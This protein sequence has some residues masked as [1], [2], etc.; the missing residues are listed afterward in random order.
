[1]SE[2]II[3]HVD[4]S[5]D[6]WKIRE[7]AQLWVKPVTEGGRGY[8][9]CVIGELHTVR[10]SLTEDVYN[11]VKYVEDEDTLNKFSFDNDEEFDEFVKKAQMIDK[12]VIL[13]VVHSH[14]GIR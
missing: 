7:L 12:D 5:S 2:E 14:E 1:M 8:K 4:S 10:L 6:K 9:H 11:L 13:T 3:K